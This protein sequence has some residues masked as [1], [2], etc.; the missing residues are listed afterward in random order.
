MKECRRNI[1]KSKSLEPAVYRKGRITLRARVQKKKK[2]KSKSGR[3]GERGNC[4]YKS[5]GRETLGHRISLAIM[6]LSPFFFS[7]RNLMSI[8]RTV[9]S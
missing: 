8:E 6:S 2:R 5:N 4:D 7:R 3:N 9:G 1:S